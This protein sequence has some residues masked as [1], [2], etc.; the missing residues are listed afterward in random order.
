MSGGFIMNNYSVQNALIK[1]EVLLK[2]NGEWLYFANPHQVVFAQKLED[3]ILALRE[4]E[5]LVKVNNWHAAGFISYEA[6]SA[7]DPSFRTLPEVG[8][9][10]RWFGLYP[11]PGVITLP[12]PENPREILNWKPTAD[13]ETFNAAM[14]R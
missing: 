9:P 1:N 5:R 10:I 4:I 7:F 8:F 6:A 13:R 3:V 14:N 2:E 11:S 12:Q